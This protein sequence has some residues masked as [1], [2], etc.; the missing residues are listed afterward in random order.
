[1][2]F[3]AQSRICTLSLAIAVS[4]FGWIGLEAQELVAD[5]FAGHLLGEWSG[6]GEYDG[7][8]L[9]VTRHWTLELG[10]RFL[11]A[12]MRV[13][14]PNGASFRGLT[15]WKAAGH[16][17]YE[18]TWLDGTG[19]MQRLDALRDASGLVSSNFLDHFSERG[20]EWR[21]WEF[22]VTG[23]DSYVERLYAQIEDRWVLQAEF[24]FERC[25]DGCSH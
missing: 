17:A 5:P 22:A 2:R 25:G 1:M 15:Y 19:R 18:V 4:T 7:N 12:D 16:G 11:K 23:D 21:R 6:H 24:M 8:R 13:T 9:D 10:E 20:T 14:M 3:Q